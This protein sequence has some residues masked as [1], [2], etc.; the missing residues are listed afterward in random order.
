MSRG[1]GDILFISNWMRFQIQTLII[2]CQAVEKWTA[3]EQ[4]VVEKFVFLS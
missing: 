3:R 1:E 4:F 2:M